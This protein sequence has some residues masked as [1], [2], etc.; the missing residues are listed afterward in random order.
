MSFDYPQKV[1]IIEVGPRDGLQDEKRNI[2]ATDKINFI[3]DLS[4][5]GFSAIEVTS[6]VNPQKIPHFVDAENVFE[7]ITKNNHC[8]YSALIANQQGFDRAVISGVKKIALVTA[9]SESFCKKNINCTIV[10]SLTR[11]KSISLK[12]KEKNIKIRVYISCAFDCPFEGKI[13]KDQVC[14]II[15]KIQEI[16]CDEISIADTTG[17]GSPEQIELLVESILDYSPVDKIAMHFHDTYGQALANVLISLQMGVSRY[18][19]SVAGIG[20]CNF[21]PGASGNLATEDLCFML[22][23]L[24][25]QTGVD[26]D[27]LLLSGNKISALLGHENYSRVAKAHNYKGKSI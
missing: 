7:S 3:N 11:I 2:S 19:T 5:C 25:I 27:K 23:G 21:S 9:A 14:A 6:F 1:Q 15:E 18:D 10:E 8:H 12:A 17:R 16:D 26:L 4:L 13:T 24:G 20:G 22:Q